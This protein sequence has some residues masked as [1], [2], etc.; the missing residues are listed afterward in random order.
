MVRENPRGRDVE[1][2]ACRATMGSAGGACGPATSYGATYQERRQ[3]RGSEGGTFGLQSNPMPGIE[4]S[5][6]TVF[7]VFGA[8]TSVS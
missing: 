2:P 8:L 6:I 3:P 1:R 4:S 5:P 7:P